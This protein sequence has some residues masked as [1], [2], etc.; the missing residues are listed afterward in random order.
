MSRI[1]AYNEQH[2]WMVMMSGWRTGMLDTYGLDIDGLRQAIRRGEL[3]ELTTIQPSAYVDLKRP[4]YHT[5][6]HRMHRGVGWRMAVTIGASL[7]F[8]SIIGLGTI[9]GYLWLSSVGG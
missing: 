7:I 2:H 4:W 1:K 9:G 6:T 5:G 8:I 3:C